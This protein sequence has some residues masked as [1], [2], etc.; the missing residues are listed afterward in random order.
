MA[1]KRIQDLTAATSIGL[2]DLFVLEQSG[3]AKNLTGQILV[4]DL[5]TYLNGHGG[6]SDITYAAPVSPSLNGTMTITMADTTQY[7]L[8]V[9]N[10]RGISSITWVD[11]GTPGDGETHTG[12]IAYND[13]TSSTVTFKDGVKGDQGQQTYVWFKWAQDYPTADADMQ[14][15]VGPYIGI[16]S[17]TASSAP[18]TYTSYTWYEYK[19]QTG[20]T[21]ASIQSIAKT[22]TSGLVDTYTVTLTNGNTS[23]FTVTNGKSISSVTMTS[24]THAAG[25]T[26]IYTIAYNDG[27]S[28]TFSVYNGANGLGSVSTVS[29]IQADGNGDVP[30]VISGNGAPTTATVGQQNQLYY[31]VNNSVLYYCA[32]ESGGTYIWQ[33]TSVTVDASLSGSSTNPVQNKV[34]TDKVGTAALNTTAQDLS[35][36]VNEILTNIP[37]AS[38]TTPSADT[39]GGAIGTGTKWAR[40]DHQHP[41]NVPTSGVPADLG[42]A[43]RGTASTY[44]RSDHVHKM[45][46]AADVGALA[47]TTTYVSSVNG[48]SGA[49]TLSI[50]A[51]SSATPADL[52]TAAAGSSSDYARADHV[53]AFP[54]W[55]R[56]GSSSSS[57][58]TQT[59]PATANELLIVGK[60][61]HNGATTCY[62]ATYKVSG[63]SDCDRLQIGGYYYGSSDFGYAAVNHDAANRTLA[64]RNIRYVSTTSGTFTF[65][66]R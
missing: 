59:Y 41:L 50:P 1:D 30:Q 4:N 35:G 54:A 45:P 36:A 28:D 55:T 2:T 13:G 14:N 47:S 29:G 40:N 24:G 23:T 60:V 8:S 49:V 31:D 62:S 33:G 7:T 10:G 65:Y 39:T 63:I 64:F 15:S 52:G 46:T 16:Y 22:S 19:G 5:A 9:T 32:G 37:A 51:A 21:G 57:G 3:A 18:A 48:S 26:D 44:A 6:I 34:I 66:Y 12:T 42:T 43:A 53:H 17:G 20:A 25:T 56:I 58:T 11:S 27:S 61:T 38:T